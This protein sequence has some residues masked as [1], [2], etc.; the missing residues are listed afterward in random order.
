MKSSKQ[1]L[2]IDRKKALLLAASFSLLSILIIAFLFLSTNSLIGELNALILSKYE[3]SAITKNSIGKDDYFRFNAGITF[4][5]AADSASSLNA[6]VIMQI[7]EAEYSEQVFWNADQLGQREIAVSRNLAQIYGLVEGDKL[8]SKHIAEGVLYEYTIVQILP[9]LSNV[10]FSKGQIPRDGV[11]VMGYDAKYDDNVSHVVLFFTDAGVDELATSISEVP[12]NLLYRSDEIF[13]VLRALLPY[14]ITFL[15]IAIALTVG[16]VFF[17]MKAIGQN[18]IRLIRLGIEQ[19]RL[20]S[21]YGELICGVGSASTII[22]FLASFIFLSII[23]YCKTSIVVL[24]LFILTDF[25]ALVLSARAFRQLLW[26]R[27]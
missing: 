10:R 14:L 24:L 1:N 2:H 21:A 20:N 27:A 26:R 8:F 23:G 9:E 22:V 5:E 15:L 4:A 3:Y 13:S 11:I 12:E 19:K 18:Y 25:A 7:S 6:D 16:L 17:L